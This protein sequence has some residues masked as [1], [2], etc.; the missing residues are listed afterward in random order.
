MTVI[1]FDG[2]MIAADKMCVNADLKLLSTKLWK[3]W[4]KEKPVFIAY[5]GQEDHGK[6]LMAWY[7]VGG[8]K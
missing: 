2:K 1:A 4:K 3:V 6:A 8:Q 7:L 5:A